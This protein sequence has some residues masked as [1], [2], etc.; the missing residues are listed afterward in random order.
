MK[1]SNVF[2]S[3][4][5]FEILQTTSL[6]QSASMILEDGESSS[7]EPNTHPR[8]DQVLVVVAG[9][10]TAEIDGE[11]QEIRGGDTVTVP[12]GTPHRFVNKSGKR[13]VTFSVYSPPAY[14]G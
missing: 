5:S 13:V 11:T 10:V 3:G 4:G 12:A 6:S 8:S 7:D 9:E 1:T 14:P 2:Q